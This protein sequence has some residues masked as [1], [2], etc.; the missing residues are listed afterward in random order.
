MQTCTA[1]S[2]CLNY[3][4]LVSEPPSHALSNTPSTI[5]P[6]G[7]D[8]PTC[9]STCECKCAHTHT[10]THFM[11]PHTDRE[12]LNSS[13]TCVLSHNRVLR[14]S[15]L[16][17]KC[18]Y[19]CEAS[20]VLDWG[21]EKSCGSWEEGHKHGV[22]SLPGHNLHRFQIQ[23]KVSCDTLLNICPANIEMGRNGSAGGEQYFLNIVLCWVFCHRYLFELLQP[24]RSMKMSFVHISGKDAQLNQGK[25]A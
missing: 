16:T 15:R 7:F 14:Y 24:V 21:R 1:L 18:F 6:N 5:A 4:V 12:A 22:T 9:L 11:G 13:V 19:V 17:K 8:F 20:V 10:H 25:A 2:R 3:L 23:K